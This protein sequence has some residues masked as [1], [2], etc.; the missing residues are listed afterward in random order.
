MEQLLLLWENQTYE[1]TTFRSEAEYTDFRRP[2]EVTFI[3]SL[4]RI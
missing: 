3:R 2:K 1:I 4:K